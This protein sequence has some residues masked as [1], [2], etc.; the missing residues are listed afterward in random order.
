[1]TDLDAQDDDA[2]DVA[3]LDGYQQ[4]AESTAAR[5]DTFEKRLTI[6]T[7]G[8][9]G[10]AGEFAEKVKKWLGHGHDMPDE[11]LRDELGDVL[12]YVAN[13]A[14]VLDF[15]LSDVADANISKLAERYPE[16]FSVERSVNRS[17]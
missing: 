8:L 4:L 7:L 2:I 3:S 12:W 15:D 5:Y 10:E 1:M 13:L 6:F 9:A 17:R 16:G 11:V 14:A